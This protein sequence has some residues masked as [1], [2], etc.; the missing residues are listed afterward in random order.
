M[1][2]N[3][4]QTLRRQKLPVTFREL[5]DLITALEHRIVFADMEQFY[6]LA[7][8]IMVKDE[9]N[10]DKYDRAF[11]AHFSELEKIDD[12]IEALIPEDWL[13][14]EFLKTLTD[15]EKAKIESLGG[16]EELIETFKK[17]LEEQKERHEGGSKW[18]GT[19][20]TSPFGN[21]GFNPEGIRVG[22][23]GGNGS[24]VKV[25][26][27]RDFKDLDD[28]IELGTRNIKMALRRLRKFA[29]SGAED[30][31]DLADTI[32]STAHN[33]GLLD[34]KMVPERR[35]AVKVLL[36]FDVGGSMDPYVKTCEELFSAARIE[37]KHMEYFYFHNFIY[38]GLWQNSEMRYD[39]VT[40][41]HDI[42]RKYGS[43]YKIIFVGDAAMATYEITHSGGSIDFMNREPGANW[44]K[45]FNDNY[46]KMVWLNPTPKEYWQHT[47]STKIIQDLMEDRMYPL[48]LKG[49]EEAMGYLSR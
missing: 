42:L 34:I 43:D 11:K 5:S 10:F 20:G 46:D 30:E 26:D 14:S 22:G 35:N 24:A 29:R 44:L 25:W 23:E 21:G 32:H 2:L 1:L 49:M 13:R 17:R 33:G 3:F 37:F 40:A 48:T 12:F 15:E 16:L 18:I 41:T 38:D 7:R 39:Q 4:F 6:Y 36:L 27:R 45:R 28:S 8:T 31:L 47:H 9:K 19:G